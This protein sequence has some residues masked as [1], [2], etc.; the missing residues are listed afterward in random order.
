MH[1]KRPTALVALWNPGR[2]QVAVEDVYQ[3]GRYGEDGSAGA[4]D[5]HARIS[6]GP[7]WTTTQVY[8]A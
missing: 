6:G 1:V 4:F 5:V 8:P 2:C 7:G 3:T